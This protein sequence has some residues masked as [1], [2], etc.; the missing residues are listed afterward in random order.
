MGRRPA[1]TRWFRIAYVSF[2]LSAYG[3]KLSDKR[4]GGLLVPVFQAIQ[5]ISIIKLLFFFVNEISATVTNTLLS[6]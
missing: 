6:R 2:A 5:I 1:L 4:V 3:R